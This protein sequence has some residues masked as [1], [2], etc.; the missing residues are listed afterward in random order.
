MLSYLAIAAV[1]ISILRRPMARL[2]AAEQAL[3]GEYRFANSRI[4]TNSEEIAFYKGGPREQEFLMKSFSNLYSHL[5]G[6]IAFKFITEFFENFVAKYIAT[7]VG[8]WAVG[9]PFFNKDGEKKIFSQTAFKV[10]QESYYRSGRMLVN[11]SQAIGRL[12]LN[13]KDLSRYFNWLLIP[14]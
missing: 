6:F 2:T 14:H 7:V 5:D 3:E 8:Y 9:R 12:V 11:L 4:I 10:R 1:L 13:A